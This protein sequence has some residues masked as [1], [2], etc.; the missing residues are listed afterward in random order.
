MKLLHGGA[1]SYHNYL[2]T[3]IGFGIAYA[4]VSHGS[5]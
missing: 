2:A 3:V 1:I 4:S 5:Y